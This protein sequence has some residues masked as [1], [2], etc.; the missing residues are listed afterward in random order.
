MV[1][2]IFNRKGFSQFFQMLTCFILHTEVQHVMITGATKMLVGNFWMNLGYKKNP[3]VQH[4]CT[5]ASS[6]H[7]LLDSQHLTAEHSRKL[8]L[9]LII[10]TCSNIKCSGLIFFH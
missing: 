5:S 10:N 1:K 7:L 9:S 8:D 2:Q 4:W 6:H 3:E